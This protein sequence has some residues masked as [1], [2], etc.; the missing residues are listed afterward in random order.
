MLAQGMEKM[1]GAEH[2]N[3]AGSSRIESL[4]WAVCWTS[5][6]RSLW[7]Y[8]WEGIYLVESV[9][10]DAGSDDPL[11]PDSDIAAFTTDRFRIAYI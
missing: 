4:R 10:K 9:D 8:V 3:A 11:E 2:V 6:G 7:I 5:L 1:L